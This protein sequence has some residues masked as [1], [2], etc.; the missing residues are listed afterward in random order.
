[1]INNTGHEEQLHKMY[2]SPKIRDIKS[3]DETGGA[4]RDEKWIQNFRR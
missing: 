3:D 1:M 2:P 4:W